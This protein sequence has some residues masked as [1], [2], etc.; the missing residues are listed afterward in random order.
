MNTCR[1]GATSAKIN[2]KKTESLDSHHDNAAE[3]VM[4]AVRY[5]ANSVLSIFLRA[6]RIFAAK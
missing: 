5:S 2:A 3:L 4:R 6:R 1:E